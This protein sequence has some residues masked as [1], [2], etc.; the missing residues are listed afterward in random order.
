MTRHA[1]AHV[2]PACGA[3]PPP[4]KY[5]DPAASTAAVALEGVWCHAGAK[6][7]LGDLTLFIPERE[8]VALLGPNGAGKT[9][10][11]RLMAL[12]IEPT[13][14]RLRLFGHDVE[15]LA[16]G[17]RIALRRRVAFVPQRT[18]YNPLVP[19]S[20]REVIATGLLAGRRFH[21]RLSRADREL[22]EA[23][24]A[25]LDLGGLLDRP[26][27]VL[28]G[29]EQQKV[30]IAR[31]LVQ[32]PDLLLLDEPTSGLDLSWQR[33]LNE[34]IEELHGRRTMT[35]VMSTHHPHHLPATCRRVILLDGGRVAF[36]GAP[37][38]PRLHEIAQALFGEDSS[39][40]GDPW[41]AA[42]A[43]L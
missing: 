10:L 40:A 8:F 37:G 43:G 38:A 25:G 24:A 35:I 36:D 31:A 27:R 15:G 34:L 26:Y 9:T 5:P 29:G 13:R 30:H 41:D 3:A 18:A 20:A 21:A 32:R 2:L 11:L 4:S 33:R 7:L 23:T 16:A 1:S 42:W 17:Q 39:T 6:A 22:V 19:L 12:G 28:S 14:G